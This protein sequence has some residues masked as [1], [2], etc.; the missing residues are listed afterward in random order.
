MEAQGNFMLYVGS[1]LATVAG[2]IK[3]VGSAQLSDTVL[4]VSIACFSLHLTLIGMAKYGSREEAERDNDLRTLALKV[5][6]EVVPMS[7]IVFDEAATDKNKN[8]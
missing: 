6:F 7:A 1:G 2:G 4:F 3:L 5:G 8:N